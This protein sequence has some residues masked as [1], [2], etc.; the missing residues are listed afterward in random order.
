MRIL[1]GEPIKID[2][3]YMRIC[4]L[5]CLFVSTYIT[6]YCPCRKHRVTDFGY[7]SPLLYRE[8]RIL[9][10]DRCLASLCFASLYFAIICSVFLFLASWVTT[11]V[12][13]AWLCFTLLCFDLIFFVPFTSGKTSVFSFWQSVLIEA[14][15]EDQSLNLQFIYLP[16]LEPGR[17]FTKSP[18]SWVPDKAVSKVPSMKIF[19]EHLRIE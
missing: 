2:S 18:P 5:V 1:F 17:S 10:R 3:M 6:E 13:F 14:P 8:S 19:A 15:Q 4:V 11:A 7:C 9:S 16:I 12:C